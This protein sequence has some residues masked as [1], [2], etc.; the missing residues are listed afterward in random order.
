MGQPEDSPSPPQS[1]SAPKLSIWERF[2][3]RAS[4][5][6]GSAASIGVLGLTGAGAIGMTTQFG[7][8]CPYPPPPIVVSAPAIAPSVQPPSPGERYFDRGTAGLQIAGN[9]ERAQKIVADL[10]WRC[11]Q[12]EAAEAAV[13]AAQAAPETPPPSAPT[14]TTTQPTPTAP[15]TGP[16]GTKT[17]QTAPPTTKTIPAP[18]AAAPSG[19]TESAPT[20]QQPRVIQP[21]PTVEPA[22]RLVYKDFYLI[23]LYATALVIGCLSIARRLPQAILR[24]VGFALGILSL[25]A[26]IADIVENVGL[27]KMLGGSFG[28]LW[29]LLTRVAAV[30]KYGFIT[31]AIV[32]VLFA[33]AYLLYLFIQG[34]RDAKAGYAVKHWMKQRGISVPTP[35]LALEGAK[36]KEA[37]FEHVYQ[38]E[39]DHIFRHR[40]SS[41]PGESERTPDQVKRSL[42]GLAFSGGGIRSATT[43]LGVLQALAEL[44]ILPFVDYLC[45]VSGGGYIGSA[46]ASLLSINS[47]HVPRTPRD[48]EFPKDAKAEHFRP[49][50]APKFST[51]WRNFPFRADRKGRRSRLAADLIGHLRTHGSFLIARRGFMRRDTMR[52]IGSM[53]TGVSFNIFGFLAVLFTVSAFYLLAVSSIAPRADDALAPP[54]V[55]KDYKRLD[56]ALPEP[57]IADT[58]VSRQ[59]TKPCVPPAGCAEETSGRVTQP[60]L[61]VWVKRNVVQVLSPIHAAVLDGSDKSADLRLRFWITFWIGM[62]ILA[63]GIVVIGVGGLLID[64]TKAIAPPLAGESQEDSFDKAL[65]MIMA[66]VTAG[67]VLLSIGALGGQQPGPVA[68]DLFGLWIPLFVMMFARIGTVAVAVIWPLASPRRWTRRFRSHWAVFETI[69]IYGVWMSVVLVALAP[70]MFALSQRPWTLTLT[71][72][73][74]LALTRF[75]TPGKGGSRTKFSMPPALL[76]AALAIAVVSVVLSG[77]LATGGA[78]LTFWRDPDSFIGL[79][80]TG[81]GVMVLLG[82]LVDHNKT[83]PHYFYRD[84]LAETYLRSEIPDEQRRMWVYRDSMELHL[85]RLHG[86]IERPEN[87]NKT[88]AELAQESTFRNRSPYLLI[89]AAINLASS[90]DLTRKDRKSGY[91]LFSKLY[92][93]STHTGFRPTGAYRNG[94]TKLAR[95]VAVS[96]AAAGSAIGFKTF[97]AQAFATVLFNVRLGYWV[98]NPMRQ[99]SQRGHEGVFWPQYL[100]REVTAQTNERTRLVNL[101]DGGHTGD[102]VGLYPLLQRR[103]KVIIVSDAEQDPALAFGSFT[104]ALRHAYIDMGIDV[105]IDLSLIRPDA[106]TGRSRNHAAIG[107]IKYPDRPDQASYLIYMKNSLT[108]DEPEPVLNYKVSC[109]DFPHESTADQFFDDAQFES[110]RSLGVHITKAT[111]KAWR[112]SPPFDFANFAHKPT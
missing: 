56:L 66:F 71:G 69:T 65:L 72:A 60:T 96:G 44:G 68:D 5:F 95:A 49:G 105:D 12:K 11:G 30:M 2:K 88:D 24:F 3:R 18:I 47:R 90:R 79:A 40:H 109:P 74:A 15:Q 73:A 42:V 111:F 6:I 85:A 84:R 107:R 8:P 97:F 14:S 103:C 81:L 53:L 22:R 104:E 62:L 91:W 33:G 89:S 112:E 45:T 50:D 27:L 29:P 59:W 41:T 39:I 31:P 110:Y 78:M 87:T 55:V 82:M 17:P 43:N 86:D 61:G 75:L 16:A 1:R 93:G 83:S 106:A 101:S 76:H 100:W 102:N 54:L 9:R 63:I 28:L 92:C 19:S 26:A 21:V 35:Q 70:L 80:A 46:L 36:E 57:A 99:T 38:A 20:T 10:A 108:G 4:N 58:V 98:E 48:A 94:E 64:L 67:I 34:R 77:V 51:E 25:L 23:A 37:G 13:A 32:F 52:A 7:D